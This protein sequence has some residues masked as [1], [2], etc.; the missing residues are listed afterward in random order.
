M[1]LNKTLSGEQNEKTALLVE[2]LLPEM[3]SHRKET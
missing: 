3:K 2:V 1:D